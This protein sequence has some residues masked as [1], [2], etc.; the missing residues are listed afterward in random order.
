MAILLNY[1]KKNRSGLHV[2]LLYTYK[3]KVSLYVYTLVLEIS[4]D[5]T[6]LRQYEAPLLTL[7]GNTDL[8]IPEF[9]IKV[10]SM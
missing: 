4:H 9:N 6:E 5:A 2:D 7:D 10:S 8:F 1:I 3:F